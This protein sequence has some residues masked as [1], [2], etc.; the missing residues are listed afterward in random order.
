MQRI[1]VHFNLPAGAGNSR[2]C[3]TVLARYQA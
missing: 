3:V 2:S 1:L